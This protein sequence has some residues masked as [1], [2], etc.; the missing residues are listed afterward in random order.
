MLH[1]TA[2]SAR[3][4]QG[5]R[6]PSSGEEEWSCQLD[7]QLMKHHRGDTPSWGCA[8]PLIHVPEGMRSFICIEVRDLLLC[9][10]SCWP[11]GSVLLSVSHPHCHKSL[12]L[13]VSP[14]SPSVIWR[15][16]GHFG[17]SG[18]HW[19]PRERGPVIC[20]RPHRGALSL[21]PAGP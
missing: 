20:A 17:I 6:V 3:R 21:H 12:S 9:T 1:L 14:S 11:V 5:L 18:G 7:R 13:A 15:Q 16:F 8:P 19:S 2:C 10:L 4:A